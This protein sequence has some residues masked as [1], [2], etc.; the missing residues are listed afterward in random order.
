MS[1]VINKYKLSLYLAIL[2]GGNIGEVYS[3][4]IEVDNPITIGSTPSVPAETT[5]N[6]WST[7]EDNT[8][9]FYRD[10]YNHNK[11]H[12]KANSTVTINPGYTLKLIATG[13]TRYNYALRC[14]N[15][16]TNNGNVIIDNFSNLNLSKPYTSKNNSTIDIING[17]LGLML[18]ATLNNTGTIKLTDSSRIH[19]YSSI[20]TNIGTIDISNITDLS[21]WYNIGTFKLEEGSTFIL[22]KSKLGDRKK[23]GYYRNFSFNPITLNGTTD[24]PVIFKYYTHES[25][26]DNNSIKIQPISGAE[27]YT[28]LTDI[29]NKTGF[30]FTGNTSNVS[31]IPIDKY[32][33]SDILTI[34]SGKYNDCKYTLD[35]SQLGII[36]TIDSSTISTIDTKLIIPRGYTLTVNGGYVRSNIRLKGGKIVFN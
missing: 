14:W 1:K 16:F 28:S 10:I 7:T 4:S 22:P 31:F 30:T 25:Y 19:I 23:I 36:P 18:S 3:A 13:Y 29:I 21:E 34:D 8:Y 33:L 35:I 20:L 2:G 6:Y 15:T 17:Q 26:I 12:W 32:T 11:T 27:T 24:K 9:V 5:Y